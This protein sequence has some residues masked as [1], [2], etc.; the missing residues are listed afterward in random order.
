MPRFRQTIAT[1][2]LQEETEGT[3]KGGFSF[4]QFLC[5]LCYLL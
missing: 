4:V 3:E 1:E 2:F 5:S